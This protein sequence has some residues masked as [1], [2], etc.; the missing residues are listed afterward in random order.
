MTNTF[1]TGGAPDSNSSMFTT[2]IY[3]ILEICEMGIFIPV[4]STMSLRRGFFDRR[5]KNPVARYEAKQSPS[6]NPRIV[7]SSESSFGRFGFLALT[8]K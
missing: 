1:K 4:Y 7:S 2:E 8:I 3:G 6:S 5:V